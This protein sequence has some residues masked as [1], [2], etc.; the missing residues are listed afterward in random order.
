MVTRKRRRIWYT[1][2]LIHTYMNV[3]TPLMACPL[4]KCIVLCMCYL[5]S[6]AIIIIFIHKRHS[7]IL[8]LYAC[9]HASPCSLSSSLSLYVSFF[10]VAAAEPSKW[11]FY[12][13]FKAKMTSSGGGDDDSRKI[14]ARIFVLHVFLVKIREANDHYSFCLAMVTWTLSNIIIDGRKEKEFFRSTLLIE[15]H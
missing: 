4:R 9:A 12:S 14:V 13:L 1:L 11:P 15:Q 3:R 2:L 7:Y 8:H 5:L 6:I 10:V